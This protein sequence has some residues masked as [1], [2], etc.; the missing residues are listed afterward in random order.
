M[1]I[2]IGGLDFKNTIADFKDRDVE[3]A[4]AQ[5]ENGNFF[6][7]LFIQTIGKRRCRRFVYNPQYIEAGNLSGIFGGLS[8][9]VVKVGGCCVSVPMSVF[10]SQFLS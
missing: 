3:G 4:P 10:V 1:G 2:A 5:I 9:T 8:L 7:R 6:I